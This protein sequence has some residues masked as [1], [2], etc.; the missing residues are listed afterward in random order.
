MLAAYLIWKLLKKTKIVSLS[1]IPLEEAFAQAEEIPDDEP[2][3]KKRGRAH[4][5]SWIWD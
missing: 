4:W 1:D 3:V 2:P 5:V